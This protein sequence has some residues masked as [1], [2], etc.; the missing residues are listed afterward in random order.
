MPGGV[1]A[2]IWTPRHTHRLFP[3]PPPPEKPKVQPYA[4]PRPVPIKGAF[5][6]LPPRQQVGNGLIDCSELVRRAEGWQEEAAQLEADAPTFNV[7]EQVGQ[8][9]AKPTMDIEKILKGWD[10]QRSGSCLK[11]E[12]RLRIKGLMVNSGLPDPGHKDVDV[13]FDEYDTDASG[14]VEYEELRNTMYALR[15]VGFVVAAEKG[16]VYEA[17]LARAAELRRRAEAALSANAAIKAAEKC[18]AEL[19]RVKE[20]INCEMEAQLGLV[21]ARRRIKVGDMVGTYAK[22]TRGLSKQDYR[23]MVNNLLSKQVVPVED[24]DA[25]FDAIDDDHSGYMD[26]QEATAAL[27]ALQQRGVAA[28]NEINEL[29]RKAAGLRRR[30]DAKAKLVQELQHL[31]PL[32]GPGSVQE[33]MRERATMS[34]TDGSASTSSPGSS[35]G[36]PKNKSLLLPLGKLDKNAP[37]GSWL[38]DSWRDWV[39]SRE[40]KSKE[41]QRTKEAKQQAVKAMKRLRNIEVAL[42]FSVWMAAYEE[43]RWQLSLMHKATKRMRFKELVRGLDAWRESHTEGV[44]I[45]QLLQT[46]LSKLAMLRE[47][48]AMG[49]WLEWL[50]EDNERKRLMRLAKRSVS[51]IRHPRLVRAMEDWGRQG[52]LY[53]ALRAP[54]P[55]EPSRVEN[56]GGALCKALSEVPQA[57]FKCQIWTMYYCADKDNYNC[58]D[59]EKTFVTR[60]KTLR[61]AIPP[62]SV[63]PKGILRH[64]PRR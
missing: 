51:S 15:E 64:A 48:R 22:T 31:P 4:L 2:S 40:M 32:T 16:E 41:K 61:P 45:L 5:A 47:S 1:H 10:P 18:E 50:A 21:M 42:Q 7:K 30:A 52:K 55:H 28:S 20:R 54:R 59:D 43:R 9:L 12:F 24:I 60:Q 23:E 62:L 46:T 34:G 49:A 56:A 27:K 36:S 33:L 53:A 39:A 8:L 6:G 44:R 17:A 63:S 29:A 14:V 37:G 11:M 26:V 57:L 19:E 38:Q 35:P 58:E 13:L 3:R 25:S